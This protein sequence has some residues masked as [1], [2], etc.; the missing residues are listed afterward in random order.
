M[1]LDGV[2]LQKIGH[3]H[4]PL[5]EVAAQNAVLKKLADAYVIDR[6]APAHDAS[7]LSAVAGALSLLKNPPTTPEPQIRMLKRRKRG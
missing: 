3:R 7:P 1:L 2:N 4:Q 5:F 6:N